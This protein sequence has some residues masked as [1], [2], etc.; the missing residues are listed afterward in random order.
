VILTEL[1]KV[2]LNV[3]T[4]AAWLFGIVISFTAVVKGQKRLKEESGISFKTYMLLV[5]VTEIVYA[6]GALMILSAMG[7]NVMEHLANLEIGRFFEIMRKFDVTTIRIIGVVGWVGF[8]VNRS[9]SF[10]TPLYLIVWG[11]RKLPSYFLVSAWT[12][13]TLELITTI[14]VFACLKIG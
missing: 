4:V 1:R 12:E 10:L 14:F 13:V 7:V 3:A 2:L 5:F 11:G 6:I 9:I 8:V